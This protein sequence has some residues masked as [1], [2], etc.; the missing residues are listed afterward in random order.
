MD[1]IDLTLQ[2][3]G[4]GVSDYN[5]LSN[6]PQINGVTLTG[7]KSSIDLGIFLPDG[8][9]INVATDGTGDFT[10]IQSA[11]DSLQGKV[12][13]GTVVVSLKA[14]DT[15]TVN[16]AI[17]IPGN[18]NCTVLYFKGSSTTRATIN[19]TGVKLSDAFV[20]QH[21]VIADLNFIYNGANNE[22]CFASDC[23]APILLLNRV[24][25]SNFSRAVSIAM[26]DVICINSI[27]ITHTGTGNAGFTCWGGHL[28]FR[29]CTLSIT[30][31]TYGINQNTGAWV[32]LMDSTYTISNVTNRYAITKNT[33]TANGTV[34]VTG[35]TE[36]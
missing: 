24:S 27:T 7:N 17:T 28:R 18:L 9:T 22:Y 5:L 8:Y 29:G 33:F 25:F 14:G 3:G 30:N 13:A 21:I 12:C 36:N 34:Y 6:Q 20:L 4:S 31:Y 10:D 23:T 15:F 26:G 1:Y 11:L 16:G 32:Q 35:T 19:C 2:E